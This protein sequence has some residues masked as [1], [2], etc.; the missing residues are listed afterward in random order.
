MLPES[1]N[2]MYLHVG[3]GGWIL[4]VVNECATGLAAGQYS[5]GRKHLL[6]FS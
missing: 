3:G 1:K 4:S 2:A 6:A 5:P